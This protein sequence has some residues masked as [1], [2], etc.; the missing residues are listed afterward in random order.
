MVNRYRA[1][2]VFAETRVCCL[3]G[4]YLRDSGFVAPGEHD[5][6]SSD[7]RAFQLLVHLFSGAEKL[8]TLL[9][10]SLKQVM[11]VHS[12]DAD[13]IFQDVDPFFGVKGRIFSSALSLGATS[14]LLLV[15][16]SFLFL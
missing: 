6:S 5:A 1:F 4:P 9:N 15:R 10:C 8:H 2:G 14:R 7:D 11:Q 3:V 12:R 13:G 16:F